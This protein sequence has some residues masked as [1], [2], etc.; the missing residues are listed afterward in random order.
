MKQVLLLDN[1]DSFTYNLKHY[2]SN[3]GYNVITIRNDEYDLDVS[4]FSHIVLSPGPGLPKDAGVMMQ[5]L[6]L[7]DSKIPVFGVCLGMQ[8]IA[9]YLGGQLYNQSIVKHGVS[10][11]IT[12]IEDSVLFENL[13]KELQVGLY[14]SWAVND[15]G[16]YKVTALSKSNTV[17]ALE[18]S[19]SKF[20]GVQFHPESVMTKKGEIIL[21]NF[22]K[23]N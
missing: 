2:I 3:L 22:L 1:Y 8:A 7:A 12:V 11:E 21:E 10:E 17:M 18:N 20:Y 9:E 23:L 19:K 14:H 5:L 6:K 13:N 15:S 16:E 4:N